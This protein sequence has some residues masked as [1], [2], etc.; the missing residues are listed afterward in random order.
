MR[1]SV[2][3]C[4]ELHGFRN[5]SLSGNLLNIEFE[6]NYKLKYN[7]YTNLIVCISDK[8]FELSNKKIIN[9]V[10]PKRTN[11]FQKITSEFN[12]CDAKSFMIKPIIDVYMGKIYSEN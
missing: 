2:N 6:M 1:I 12:I 3:H 10:N 4:C 5:I 11:I 8:N 9:T 7:I